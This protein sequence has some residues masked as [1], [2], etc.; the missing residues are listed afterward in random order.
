MQI[1]T[2]GLRVRFELFH[3]LQQQRVAGFQHH[4]TRR[5]FDTLTA[6]THGYQRYAMLF[7]KTVRAHRRADQMTAEGNIGRTQHALGRIVVM[8]NRMIGI[9]QSVRFLQIQQIAY[10]TCIHQSV[11]AHQRFV[12]RH[13]R[14]DLLVVKMADLNQTAALHVVQS[15]LADRHA[16]MFVVRR[17][18]HLHRVIARALKRL[19]RRFAVRQQLT[20]RD[21]AQYADS[22][23]ED[24][25]YGRRQDVHRLARFLFVQ[26][27]DD[28]V[29]R[30]TDQRTHTTHTRSVTQ[31]DQQ[32][33]R[34]DIEFLRPHLDDVHKQRHHR[35]VAQK[36]TQC[37]YRQ[38]QSQYRLGITLRRT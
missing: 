35:R 6:T 36:R 11:T 2:H 5:L 23:A 29:R 22:Q 9:D 30:R 25:R 4:L 14:Y 19:F 7:L 15:Q 21:D 12:V 18:Q 32:F 24:T 3:A 10:L 17:N 8:E 33:G 20:H 38:H 31:R 34:R 16:D 1:T 26:T 27:A 13:R 28:Q 37:R